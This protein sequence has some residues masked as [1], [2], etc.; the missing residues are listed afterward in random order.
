METHKAFPTLYCR[1]KNLRQWR[2]W[3]SLDESKQTARYDTEWGIVGGKMQTGHTVF[4]KGNTRSTPLELAIIRANRLWENKKRVQGYTEAIPEESAATIRIAPMLAHEYNKQKKKVVLPCFVQPKLDGVRAL[5]VHGP[6]G[7]EIRS[8]TGKL[9]NAPV[10]LAKYQDIV[11]DMA[12]GSFL[13]GELYVHGMGFDT[14]SGICRADDHPDKG[15]LEF[16][17]FDYYDAAEPTLPFKRRVEVLGDLLGAI[18]AC[19]VDTQVVKTHGDIVEAHDAYVADGYEGVMVRNGASVYRLDYRSYGLLKLKIFDDNEFKCTG[20]VEGTGKF[21]KT[22]VIICETADGKAF[23]VTPEGSFAKKRALFANMRDE[24]Y[25]VGMLYTVRHQGV[26]E[27]GVPRF[28][29]GV[30]FRDYE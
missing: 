12:Q 28:P 19:V 25:G 3:V 29:V 23:R 4:L 1:K 11:A 30:A 22:P 18:N 2:V 9:Y 15:I 27:A 10:I 5:I 6:E 20:F 14:V 13:D 8:R 21:R 17:C 26:S 24:G 7:I 16:H